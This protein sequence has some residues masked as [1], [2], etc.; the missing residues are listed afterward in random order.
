MLLS[1][2]L[3]VKAAPAPSPVV[4]SAAAASVAT[5]VTV[6]EANSLF[7]RQ[8][9]TSIVSRST[10]LLDPISSSIAIYATPSSQSSNTAS[11]ERFVLLRTVDTRLSQILLNTLQETDLG[12]MVRQQQVT[13][14]PVRHPGLAG[15][16]LSLTANYLHSEIVSHNAITDSSLSPMEKQECLR[17]LDE[18]MGCAETLTRDQIKQ[19]LKAYRDLSGTAMTLQDLARKC[20]SVHTLVLGYQRA[21]T[22]D[23]PGESEASNAFWSSLRQPATDSN[24]TDTELSEIIRA[25]SGHRIQHI[26]LKRCVHITQAG[27]ATLLILRNHLISLDLDQ[28]ALTDLR[29]INGL[30]HLRELSLAGSAVLRDISALSTLVNLSKLNLSNCPN[31]TDIRALSTLLKLIELDLSSCSTLADIQALSYL[32]RLRRLNLNLCSM[33]RDIN[34]LS[35]LIY[36]RE[37][38]LHGAVNLTNIDPLGSLVNLIKLKLSACSNLRSIGVLSRLTNLR[39]L[40]LNGCVNPANIGFLSPL[41]RLIKLDISHCATLIDVNS[42]R[43]LVNLQEVNLSY[44]DVLTDIS[45][46][47]HLVHLTKINL[48]CCFALRNIG[49]LASLINLQMLD[50]RY[51]RALATG[52]SQAINIPIQ[53]RIDIDFLI[54]LQRLHHLITNKHFYQAKVCL[55]ILEK[56]NNRLSGSPLPD[57]F[58]Q[59]DLLQEQKSPNFDGYRPLG[60]DMSIARDKF[61]EELTAG[62]PVDCLIAIQRV[63]ST[64]AA[65]KR[66]LAASHYTLRISDLAIL[67]ELLEE[68]Q[69]RTAH[70][71]VNALKLVHGEIIYVTLMHQMSLARGRGENGSEL[72]ATGLEFNFLNSDVT[73]HKIGIVRTQIVLLKCKL[74]TLAASNPQR[75][76]WV[77]LLVHYQAR[78]IALTGRPATEIEALIKQL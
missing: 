26:S 50:L 28:L 14:L 53:T 42:L 33:L 58:D 55:Q 36:L 45:A 34:A 25:F 66:A 52:Q 30:I 72:F 13:P 65:E 29:A 15:S 24:L 2:G 10:L 51:C 19:Y 35:T 46:L 38:E 40:D 54:G 39:D 48:S 11:T 49:A 20:P 21:T 70:E 1:G 76:G 71:F 57:L 23:S 41:I 44:C 27:L 68:R 78:L 17:A 64:Y 7:L 74:E 77:N 37:L 8:Q 75:D 43:T 32:I 47:S 22:N 56:S 31:L 18:E 63:Q 9:R 12:N 16:I 73:L 3:V 62:N 67:Y 4:P 6:E 5:T 59:M 60:K 69:F 61:F